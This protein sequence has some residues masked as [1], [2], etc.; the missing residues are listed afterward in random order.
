MIGIYVSVD[1]ARLVAEVSD[2]GVGV[3]GD[4][5]SG[6]ANIAQRASRHGGRMELDT[7]TGEGTVVRWVIPTDR[8]EDE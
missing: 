4:R 6:L 1:R 2:D 3:V 5:R 7:A 8:S